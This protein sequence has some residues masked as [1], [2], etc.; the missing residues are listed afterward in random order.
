MKAGSIAIALGAW[1]WM[2]SG[3][4]VAAPHALLTRHVPAQARPENFVGTVSGSRVFR[5]AITLKLHHQ[6]LLDNFLARLQDPASPVYRHYLTPASF[7]DR[8]GPTGAEYATLRQFAIS[9]GLRVTAEA[10]NRYVLEVEASASAIQQAFGVRLGQYRRTD[11]TVFTAPDREPVMDIGVPVLHISGLDDFAPPVSHAI[12]HGARAHAVRAY[13]SAPDGDY[14]GT[15]MR[16]AYYGGTALTGSG[17]IVA[18]VEY[19]GYNNTDVN[20]YFATLGQ[21]RTVPVVG[22]SVDGTS[23]RCGILCDDFEPS[24]DIEQTIA[25]AP[26]LKQ[27]SFYIGGTPIAILNRIAT[28]DT[29]KT[30]SSSYGWP[31]DADVEDPVY[32]E[33]AAQGQTIVDGSGDMGDLLLAGGVWPAD[34][35]WVTGVGGTVLTTQNGGAWG[36]ETAWAES[37]G[38]PSP[39]DQALPHWQKRFVNASNHGST[40]ARNVPDVSA[41]ADY[42][43]YACY[44]GGCSGGNGGTSFSAPRWAGFI[45]LVNQQA[46]AAHLPTVGY[47]NRT[48]YALGSVR[49]TT[50]HDIESGANQ[51]YAAIEGYDLVTGFGS[52][53]PALIGVLA[54]T[55]K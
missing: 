41:E 7:T 4:A 5:L 25:M 12:R 48:L 46:I 29:A 1:C 11:G 38:G 15:D 31:A 13:G 32:K 6:A 39:D 2:A 52:P 37:G 23:L 49:N 53:Q 14:T 36:G 28:D 16:N 34:D 3:G 51:G 42:D 55:A 26:G 10:P 17:Q 45:A 47:L 24:I 43:N 19:I 8:F 44:D 50:L 20:N 9:H 22:I 21:P 27:V 54:G 40:M 35:P 18:L 33:Y 30:I